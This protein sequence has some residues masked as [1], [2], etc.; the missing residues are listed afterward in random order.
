MNK[1]TIIITEKQAKKLMDLT[2]LKGEVNSGL[3]TIGEDKEKEKEENRTSSM[4]YTEED[5]MSAFKEI[6]KFMQKNGLK[7]FPM[8]KIKLN[9]EKQS[10]DPLENKTG[11]YNPE[12]KEVV[13]FINE[14][15]PKDV[16]RSFAHEMIHHAQNLRGENLNF[17]AKDEVK[18]SKKLEKIESEAYLKGNI[19]FRK[20]TEMKMD[21]K[22]KK[23][24]SKNLNEEFII[25]KKQ[26]NVL[27]EEIYQEKKA[28]P[29]VINPDKVLIVK[30]Y[31]DGNFKRGKIERIGNDGYSEIIP[32]IAMLGSDMEVLKNFSMEQCQ[33]LLIDKYQ[34]MFYDEDEKEKFFAQVLKDWYYDKISQF[35]ALSVTHL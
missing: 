22:K 35:G 18:N 1:S 23:S 7:V 26:I 3:L 16:L 25:T 29:Y 2:L 13:V 31:L 28:K 5:Y 4:K 27:S 10:E 12:F 6:A 19:F 21:V 9:N 15:H 17:S 20:W 14:R 11:Y 33:D 24:K 32:V 34:N 30:R 8:P